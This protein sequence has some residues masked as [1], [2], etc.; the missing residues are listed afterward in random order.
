MRFVKQGHNAPFWRSACPWVA[1]ALIACLA[2]VIVT[3]MALRRAR[4][5]IA[6]DS[7]VVPSLAESGPASGGDEEAAREAL[8]V[9]DGASRVERGGGAYGSL[10]VA[11]RLTEEYPARNAIERV[12]SHL[13]T[14]GWVPLK[15]D[16]LNPGLPSSHVRGWTDYVDRTANLVRH[17]YQWS[18]EWQDSRGNLV[19]YSLRYECPEPGPSDLRSLWVTGLWYPAAQAKMMQQFTR[20][21]A[22]SRRTQGAQ[23]VKEGDRE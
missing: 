2:C 9:L 23:N 4:D 12:S 1:V 21:E 20:I 17:V 22:E 5:R 10:F 18:A 16:W 8:I 19:D 7:A 3:V 14:L 6:V 15:E 13:R 11:Y